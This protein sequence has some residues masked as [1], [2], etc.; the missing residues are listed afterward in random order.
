MGEFFKVGAATEI[1]PKKCKRVE[2]HGKKIALCP[3][4]GKILAID[5]A[6]AHM[7]GSLSEGDI[8]G[9]QIECPRHGARFK[10]ST[11]EMLRGPGSR[12]VHTYQVRINGPEIELEV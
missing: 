8:D 10:I 2:V 12:G 11:G 1:Q 4:D 9:D 3:V 6:C 5:D 7:G